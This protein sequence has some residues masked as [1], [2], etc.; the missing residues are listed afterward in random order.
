MKQFYSLAVVVCLAGCVPLFEHA[1]A[2]KDSFSLDDR[3]PGV[4][5]NNGHES[6][7]RLIDKASG[8]YEW[9]NYDIS[10]TRAGK[11]AA[12][13]V[14]QLGDLHIGC[15]PYED[16]Q[17]TQSLTHA[18]LYEINER[19]EL[20]MFNWDLERLV[21]AIEDGQLTG[22]FQQA[23]GQGAFKVRVQSSSAE[24]REWLKG[25]GRAAFSEKPTFTYKR[26][27]ATAP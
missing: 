17:G 21:K 2:D 3:L 1:I 11:A 27:N 9:Q 8:A 12:I 25:V 6:S 13:R 23:K 16:S 24:L 22:T 10:G 7:V 19:G 5:S 20:A 18:L 15:A 14:I 26:V 4:W